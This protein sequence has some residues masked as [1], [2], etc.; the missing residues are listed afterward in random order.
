MGSRS[1]KGKRVVVVGASTGIGRELAR[2]AIKEGARVLM[3]ARRT[4]KLD[5]VGRTI[6]GRGVDAGGGI[7]GEETR[8]VERF[9]GAQNRVLVHEH[10]GQHGNFSVFGVRRLPVAED[11]T[12][13][14][15]RHRVFGGQAGHLPRWVA[16]KKGYGAG[17]P[18]D[19]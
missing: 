15:G 5:G 14:R 18:G 2:Q 19:M 10:G 8:V 3:A 17:R 11:V 9:H 16:S 6:T 4:D 1:L 13:E 7:A 12:R